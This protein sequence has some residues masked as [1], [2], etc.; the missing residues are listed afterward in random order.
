M[1]YKNFYLHVGIL[2]EAMAMPIMAKAITL[3]LQM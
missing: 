1:W 3:I 2:S